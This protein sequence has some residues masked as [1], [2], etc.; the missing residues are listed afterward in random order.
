MSERV[1]ERVSEPHLGASVPTLKSAVSGYSVRILSVRL[2][3]VIITRHYRIETIEMVL[4]RARDAHGVCGTA[5]LW[6]FGE[7]QAKVLS[8]TLGYL[9]PFALRGGATD[10]AAIVSELRRE[11]NF[12]GFKGVSV[13]AF[14]AFDMAITDL[15]CRQADVSLGAHLGRRR[16]EI[17]AYWSGL[18]GNQS[19]P[20][21]LAE[22]DQKLDEGFRA[23]KLRTGN[24][25]LDDDMHR[26]TA[27]LDR[28]PADTVL[29]LDAVQ[30][31][32]VAE[33]L[34]ACERMEGMPIRWLEDPLVH[35]DYDGLA[36]VVERSSIPIATGENEYLSDGFR[37][38]FA[39]GPRYLLADLERVGGVGEW[40][41]VAE[42]AR[43]RGVTLTPHV[44]PHIALQLCCSLDQAETWIEYIPWWNP[45]ATDPLVVRDGNLTVPD[46]A[47]SGLD[48]DPERV[49][50]FSL[51]SWVDL[52]V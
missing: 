28:L 37:Q 40:L 5:T 15:A 49:E 42:H 19:L 4:L 18:F 47:A 44:Y 33:T 27:V 36:T 25:P 7:A 1:S 13:F 8:T 52:N 3:H 46:I 2:D 30:S 10:P 31:W 14:S 12:F 35:N 23:M 16:T 48:L 43:T 20:E 6:C 24:R 50:A 9:A 29:M 21:I 45:L 17:P 38:I 41:K 11:I 32:T 39:A 26:V 22:V 34:A 51:T